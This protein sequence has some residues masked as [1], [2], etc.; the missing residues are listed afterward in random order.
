MT[1]EI[2]LSNHYSNSDVI[3][4]DFEIISNNNDEISNNNDEINNDEINIPG[5][6]NVYN[7]SNRTDHLNIIDNDSDIDIPLLSNDQIFKKTIELNDYDDECNNDCDNDND[8]DDDDNKETF[9]NM[10]NNMNNIINAKR[11][12]LRNINNKIDPPI[13]VNINKSKIVQMQW[14]INC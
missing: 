13:N 5:T 10:N 14:R 4:E 7:N 3:N 2:L 9:S 8:N 1:E 11:Y 6:N 12:N